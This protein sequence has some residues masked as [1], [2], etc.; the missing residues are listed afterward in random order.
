MAALLRVRGRV[1][2]KREAVAEV[3]GEAE[4]ERSA[5]ALGMALR[6]LTGER[7]AEEE[8]EGDPV[9]EAVKDVLGLTAAL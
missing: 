4:K 6:E 3:M 5:L 1:A 7:E 2:G 9:E 8:K